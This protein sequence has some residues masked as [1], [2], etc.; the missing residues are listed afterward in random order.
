M[1]TIAARSAELTRAF[2]DSPEAARHLCHLVGTTR[3]AADTLQR[4]PDLVARLPDP[5]RLATRERTEL[6]DS[7]AL[8][9]GWRPEREER[10]Q[11][12]RRWKDRH[13]LGVIGRD[14][15]HGSSVADVG[16]GVTAIAEAS[17][18]AALGA[19]EPTLPLAV[20]ALG[21]FGGAELSYASDLDVVLVYDGS[22]AAEFAEAT[23]LAMDLRRFVA[24]ATPVERIWSV[25]LDLRPE[26]KQGP[27]ARSIEG[28]STY[29]HRWA[30][31]WER[32]AMLRAR[33]VAGDPDGGAP[34]H[35]AARRVRVA[36]RAVRRRRARDPPDQGAHRARAD[37][38]RRGPGVPPQ[39]GPRAPCRTSSG[40]SS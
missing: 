9:V 12:L 15:L 29:F 24:G 38:A 36:A 4:N 17:L 19:I 23:R 7:A 35:G 5:A 13:L 1:S 22:S 39:A 33:P 3:L 11:A 16:A 30:N 34:F 28:Y 25:D 20:I 27:V 21:R 8:A 2:R 37:P 32:Q 10:Q 14:V 6:V 31:V 40:R 18:E 26:G